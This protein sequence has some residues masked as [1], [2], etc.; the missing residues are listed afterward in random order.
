MTANQFSMQDLDDAWFWGFGTRRRKFMA[1]T[2]KKASER[3]RRRTEGLLS[4]FDR[5]GKHAEKKVAELRLSVDDDGPKVFF[6]HCI[7]WLGLRV[8]EAI[9]CR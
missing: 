9:G 3:M 1:L 5:F 4:S 8:Q 2:M 6:E 7:R